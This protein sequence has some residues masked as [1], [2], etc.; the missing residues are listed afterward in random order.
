MLLTLVGGTRSTFAQDSTG[1]AGGGFVLSRWGPH[2]A[3]SSASLRFASGDGATV[4][5]F[6]AEAG[7]DLGQHL[8]VSGEL[9]IARRHDTL[10]TS[11]YLFGPFQRQNRYRDLMIAGLAHWKPGPATAAVRAALVGGIEAVQQSNLLRIADGHFGAGGQLTYGPFGEEENDSDWTLG[12]VGGAEVI[13]A[14][15]KHV[16]IVPQVRLHAIARDSEVRTLGTVGLTK[17][18]FRAGVGVR[19]VF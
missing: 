19:A 13:V 3:P 16:R 14:A 7:A 11:T 4:P 15:S 2:E 10:Q 9:A 8:G 17:L 12:L 1:Y 5:G 18:V 6:F